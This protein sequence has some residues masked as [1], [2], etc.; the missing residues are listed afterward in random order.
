MIRTDVTLTH[1]EEELIELLLKETGKPRL[2]GAGE[3]HRMS[4][5]FDW[6]IN[7]KQ[8]QGEELDLANKHVRHQFVPLG[9]AVAICPWNFPFMLSLAK[10]LPA[11]QM[12]NAAIV[13][14]SPFTP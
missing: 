11:V 14:P 10:I 12:G 6:H 9:V 1:T 2:I 4:A 7:L 5:F 13:K 3:V 8:P